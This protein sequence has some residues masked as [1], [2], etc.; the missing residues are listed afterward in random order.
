M[1]TSSI[2]PEERVRVDLADKALQRIENRVFQLS[3]ALSTLTREDWGTNANTVNEDSDPEDDELERKIYE[4]EGALLNYLQKN[5]PI[6]NLL[7]PATLR[8][9]ILRIMKA[10]FGNTNGLRRDCYGFPID[11]EIRAFRLN[12]S[13]SSAVAWRHVDACAEHMLHYSTTV[14]DYLAGIFWWN[15]T[16]LRWSVTQLA[17]LP[18]THDAWLC[19][20]RIRL[21]QRARE[22]IAV[23]Q[24]ASRQARLL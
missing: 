24:R 11:G 14:K 13:Q 23:K 7:I 3:D 10:T 21:V 6:D 2:L 16:S 19:L 22:T 15:H 9:A 18:E 12:T 5:E 20:T 4:E 1:H 17:P 8:S